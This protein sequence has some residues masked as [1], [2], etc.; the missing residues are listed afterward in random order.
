MAGSLDGVILY[1][2]AGSHQRRAVLGEWLCLW[3]GSIVVIIIDEIVL[4]AVFRSVDAAY[5]GQTSTDLQDREHRDHHRDHR[6]AGDWPMV[7]HT[8][9]TCLTSTFYCVQQLLRLR[10]A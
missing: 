9:L 5:E 3:V 8:S 10:K 4:H 7:T 6:P 1:F 2:A